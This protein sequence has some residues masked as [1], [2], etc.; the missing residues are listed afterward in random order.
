MC[1]IDPIFPFV[2]F[3]KV[4]TAADE[5]KIHKQMMVLAPSETEIEVDIKKFRQAAYKFEFKSKHASMVPSIRGA[6]SSW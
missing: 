5:I 1:C 2:C 3:C 4:A 6:S